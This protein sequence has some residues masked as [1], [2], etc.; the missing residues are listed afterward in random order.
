VRSSVDALLDSWDEPFEGRIARDVAA[1]IPDGGVLFAGSSMPVRDLDM[2]MRPRD[3]LRVLANRGASGI[4]GL[5]STTLGVAEVSGPTYALLGDLSLIHDA[6]G[7][8]WGARRGP[9]VVLVIVDNGG[10]GIFS[11]LPQASLPNDEFELLFGTP[12]RL[13]L[14]AIARAAGAGV[15]TVDSARVLLP[16]IREAVTAGGVQ[17]VRVRVD[18]RRAVE[19][20]REVSSAVSSALGA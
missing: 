6:S 7:F 5:V 2:Y 17:V 19:L 20:R 12:H 13:D 10:G 8:L 3:G 16:A 18:R 15:R 11:L 1:A 14:E 9:G 4:D